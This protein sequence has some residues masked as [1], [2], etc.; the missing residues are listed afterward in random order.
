MKK[1]FMIV[2]IMLIT[3]L[4]SYSQT[5]SEK[6]ISNE[7]NLWVKSFNSGDYQKAIEIYAEDYVGY[8]PNQPDQTVKDIEEQYRNLFHN[9]SLAVN[10]SMEPS[11]IKVIGGYAYVVTTMTLSIKPSSLPKPT[12]ATDK[13]MQIWRK[14]KA[15]M[16]KIIRSSAFPFQNKEKK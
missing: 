13:V 4:L 8:Y 9:K 1:Y 11:E 15:G 6:K 16:W 7:I 2:I 5:D 10:V 12:I 3:F 14:E